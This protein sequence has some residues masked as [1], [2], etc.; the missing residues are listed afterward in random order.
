MEP[1]KYSIEEYNNLLNVLRK[2][3]EDIGLCLHSAGIIPPFDDTPVLLQVSFVL[4]EQT[5]PKDEEQASIDAAFKE[6]L[7]DQQD[8]DYQQSK[9]K[10][11]EDF[12]NNEGFFKDFDK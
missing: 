10:M 2:R 11:L 5:E 12:E 8:F 9:K 6:L 1:K 3:A 4:G 7:Q